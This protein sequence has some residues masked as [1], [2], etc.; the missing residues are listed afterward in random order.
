VWLVSEPGEGS[1][2]SFSMPRADVVS[3][4]GSESGGR[5]IDR[6]TAHRSRGSA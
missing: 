5:S 2:F 6:T 3:L 4:V 1:T